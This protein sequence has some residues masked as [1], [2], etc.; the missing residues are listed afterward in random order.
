MN[1][2]SNDFVG[3]GLLAEFWLLPL[4]QR[5]ARQAEFEAR[6][7]ANLKAQAWQAVLKASLEQAMADTQTRFHSRIDGC[8]L[9]E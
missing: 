3:M 1:V 2:M 6:Q 8:L 7:A 9:P 4:R 5:V